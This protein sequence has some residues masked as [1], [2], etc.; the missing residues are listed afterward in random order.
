MSPKIRLA[1]FDIC[2]AVFLMTGG[3]VGL[4]GPRALRVCL[5]N[6]W[7]F[8]HGCEMGGAEKSYGEKRVM[9]S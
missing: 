1:H 4:C 6:F 5:V 9:T 8:G 3:L 7:D 2:K